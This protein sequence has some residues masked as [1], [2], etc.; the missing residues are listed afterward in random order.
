MT[1]QRRDASDDYGYDLVHEEVGGSAPPP[2]PG[3]GRPEA[4]SPSGSPADTGGDY[5]YDEAH[6]F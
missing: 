6:D 1:E 2:A 5:G 4:A 3:R